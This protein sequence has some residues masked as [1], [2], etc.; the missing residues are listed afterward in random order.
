M[1]RVQA[2]VKT[3]T[4][5]CRQAALDWANIGSCSVFECST[6]LVPSTDPVEASYIKR[7]SCQVMNAQ[8]VTVTLH[9]ESA[10]GF[11]K[12]KLQ[13]GVIEPLREAD[14]IE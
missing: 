7:R 8:K 11:D 5:L 6:G 14:L 1:S 2:K 3:E 4:R 9:A 13:N 10:K 12:A